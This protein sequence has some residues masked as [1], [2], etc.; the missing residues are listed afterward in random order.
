MTLSVAVNV[1]EDDADYP[2]T[3]VEGR[4]VPVWLPPT[5]P[6]RHVPPSCWFLSRALQRAKRQGG[7]ALSSEAKWQASGKSCQQAQRSQRLGRATI[8]P[9]RPSTVA[10]SCNK[11]W[12]EQSRQAIV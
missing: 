9:I 10:M 11:E 2:N 8:G 1:A 6:L 3:A 4:L 7:I 5:T 12:F